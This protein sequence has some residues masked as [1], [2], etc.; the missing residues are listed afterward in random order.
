MDGDGDLDAVVA[1]Q[2][3]PDTV[4]FNEGSLRFVEK[5][6]QGFLAERSRDVA[7]ADLDGDGDLDAVFA[8]FNGRNRVYLNDGHGLFSLKSVLSSDLGRGLV[9]GCDTVA[10]GNLGGDDRPDILIGC[11]FEGGVNTGALG[12]LWLT[13]SL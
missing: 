10:V 6:G 11:S 13:G 3:A 9:S 4:Y 8:D 5:T 7:L 1:R 12:L 2:G